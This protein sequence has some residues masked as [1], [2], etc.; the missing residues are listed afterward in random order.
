MAGV[1]ADNGSKQ[2]LTECKTNWNSTALKIHLFKN[3]YTPLTTSVI[4]DFTESTFAGY[5]AASLTTWPTPTVAA[6]VASMAAAAVTFTRSTTGATEAIYGYYVTDNA[7]TVLLW[8]E[9][10]A[11]AP[12]N[13]TNSGD[14]YTVTPTLAAKDV[15]V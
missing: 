10:D 11:N 7:S 13:V 14:S 15:S 12:I 9:R 5:A 6:H 4:G 2:V 3:N 8:A 1:L